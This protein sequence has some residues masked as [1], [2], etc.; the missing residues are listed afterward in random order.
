MSVT[1][2][3]N[4]S[5]LPLEHRELSLAIGGMTCGACV[6]RVERTLNKLEGVMAHVNYASERATVSLPADMPVERLI[7]RITH[8]GYTAELV[9][10]DRQG[11]TASAV[12]LEQ[13]VRYLRRRLLRGRRAVHAAVRHVDRCSR[14]TRRCGSPAGSG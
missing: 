1:S 12:E 11:A 5:T 10:H 9:G 6:A 4:T 7:D 8:A 3:A 14:S 2:P 13:R